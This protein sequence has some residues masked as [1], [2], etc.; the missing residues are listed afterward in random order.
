VHD[1]SAERWLPIP[2]FEGRYEVS[3]HGL[4]RSLDRVQVNRLGRR[5]FWPGQMLKIQMTPN[6]YSKVCLGGVNWRLVHRLVLT[7][8]VGP[9][10][11]GMECLHGNDVRTDNR[12]ANLSWGT[13]E[14]NQ[15]GAVER[16]RNYEAAKTHCPRRHPLTGANLDPG[17]A[18]R[19]H[20]MCR[21]CIKAYRRARWNRM[22]GHVV[23]D[24][25]EE[26]DRMY[27]EIMAGHLDGR[28]KPRE[29]W[30][31]IAS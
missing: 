22:N 31:P 30:I 20:R 23:P 4:V 2:G 1:V 7:A 6:G 29:K 18:K 9:C 19:N 8:F 5:R 28:K 11:D 12:L 13:H 25:Q 3:D 21:A 24:L 14:E 10:P 17:H 16:G 26:S 15:Q 27:A